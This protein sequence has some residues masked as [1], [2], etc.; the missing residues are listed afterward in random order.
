MQLLHIQTVDC[1]FYG[2]YKFISSYV[3]N[4]ELINL[5]T[6][7]RGDDGVRE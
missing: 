5:K 7:I 2:I 6:K 4:H 1:G 3:L